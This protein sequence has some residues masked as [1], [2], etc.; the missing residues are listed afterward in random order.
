MKLASRFIFP[1]VVGLVAAAGASGSAGAADLRVAVGCPP[2][3]ACGDWHFAED[4]KE[5]LAEHGI[6]AEL[7]LGGALGPDPDVVDQMSQGLVEVGL[8]NFVMVRQFEPMVLGFMTPYMFEDQAHMFRAIDEGSI[9]AGINETLADEGLVLATLTGVGGPIGIFNSQRPV[10]S[11]EDLEGLRLRA[12]DQSQVALFEA[13]GTQGV[14]VDMAEFAT[15][16]QSGVVDGYLNPA[17][18]ALIFQHTDFL[19]HYSDVGAGYGVRSALMSREWYEGLGE[20]TRAAVDDALAHAT[21]RNREWTLE[22]SETE[23]PQLEENGVT[24]TE[25]SEEA[26]E[27]FRQRARTVWG[28]LMPPE[29]VETFEE[30][31]DATRE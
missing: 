16:V 6:E 23:I 2:V 26:L 17:L 19:D 12:I 27:E 8:T 18:V 10:E 14:V 30:I 28:E 29:H 21:E 13:W 11:V 20:D 25:V 1:A 24:V 5:K 22:I 15:S 7:A 9:V 3:E 4:F 31:S